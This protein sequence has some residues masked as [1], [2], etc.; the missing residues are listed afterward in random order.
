MD[1][2]CTGQLHGGA[3]GSPPLVVLDIPLARPA[4]FCESWHVGR[5]EDPVAQCPCAD[6]DRL[7]QIGIHA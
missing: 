2:R 4:V 7:Q 6:L 1:G 5:D 3:A